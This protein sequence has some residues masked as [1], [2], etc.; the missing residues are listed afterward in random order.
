MKS[1]LTE[2]E[3]LLINNTSRNYL[4]E[5]AKWTFFLSIVGFIGIGFLVIVGVFLV[6]MNN[7]DI[8]TIMGSEYPFDMGIILSATYIVIALI[9]LFPVLYLFKFSR[10]LKAA[11]NTKNDDTLAGAFEMLKS[12]YKFIGVFMIII[13]SLYAMMFV[14]GLMGVALS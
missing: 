3:Q 8:N 7:S 2:L 5:I 14:F 13:L 4:K 12:H 1:P 11:L 6:F 10:K 9:Y